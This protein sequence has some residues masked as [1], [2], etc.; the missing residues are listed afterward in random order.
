MTRVQGLRGA[1]TADD[2]TKDAIVEA[3]GELLGKLGSRPSSDRQLQYP[4]GVAADPTG[5]IYVSDFFA[6]R[7]W[8]AECD[9]PG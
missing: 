7:I 5:R 2:N 3:T 8:K 4:A 9:G 6:N 1:T